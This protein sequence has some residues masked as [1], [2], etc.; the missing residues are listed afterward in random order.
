MTVRD[1]RA[2]SAEQ[3]D[4]SFATRIGIISAKLYRAKH[5]KRPERHWYSESQKFF[6]IFPCGMIEQAYRRLKADGAPSL[7]PLGPI[8]RA[9][10]VVTRDGDLQLT[11][12][13][14]KAGNASANRRQTQRVQIGDRLVLLSPR[15]RQ[16]LKGLVEGK[17]NKQIAFDLRISRHTVDIYRANLMDKTKASGLSHLVRMALIARILDQ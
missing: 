6:A 9:R 3:W 8:G 12:E 13:A 5:N 17:A 2:I 11:L 16:I 4:Q 1:Y 7:K 10:G 15:E 14:M